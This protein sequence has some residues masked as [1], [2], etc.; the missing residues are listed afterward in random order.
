[1]TTARDIMHAGV[2]C[3]GEN[4]TLQH[5][6]QTMRDQDIGALPIC[7]DDDRL[8]GIITDRD[9]VVKCLAA[10]GD[11]ATMTAGELAQ[12][13]PYT[14]DVS[15]DVDQVL[16]T[17]E[18]HRIHRV[19]V[20]EEHRVVGMIAEAD[21]ARHLPEQRVGEFVELVCAEM[22]GPSRAS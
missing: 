5:A 12:G 20:L 7:G 3:V 21:L 18:E 10:G 1:M 22:T 9:I 6:A 11:P 17:M 4:E 2:T 13:T 16:Q 19:P 8:H 14:V 15:A